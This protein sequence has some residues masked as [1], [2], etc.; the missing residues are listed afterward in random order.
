MMSMT[1][2]CKNPCCKFDFMLFLW[3]IK[4][5]LTIWCL[6]FYVVCVRLLTK[7]VFSVFVEVDSF[8]NKRIF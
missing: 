5:I 7:V 8:L 6:L 1:T 3:V 4:G 2:I